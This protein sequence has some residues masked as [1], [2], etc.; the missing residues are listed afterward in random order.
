M[1][2]SDTEKKISPFKDFLTHLKRQGFVIGVDH[3]LRLQALLDMLG[4]NSQP[5]EL[6][7]LICPI[8]A[9][10]E[11]Q[12][13]QFYNAFDLYFKPAK[14]LTPDY[15]EISPPESIE[16]KKW[17]YFLLGIFLLIIIAI[18]GY[19]QV[20][21]KP[22]Q[23]LKRPTP[24]P[25]NTLES[26][27]G[28][29]AEPG[30]AGST[31]GSTTS[32]LV[33]STANGST[34]SSPL[35]QPDTL[36]KSEPE[37][38]FYQHY[39]Q[40]IRW[41]G[42]MTPIIIFLLTEWYKFNR[43]KLVLLKQQSKKPPYVWPI[44]VETS[45]LGFI[46]NEQ[47]YL[48]ARSMR[49]RLKS[50]VYQLDIN[51]TISHALKSA[52]FPEKFCYKAVTKPP[53]YLILIDL[54][55]FRDHYAHF[56][57]HIAK[58][59]EN[60]DVHV[61]RY[62]YENNPR[63][64]FQ[65]ASQERI[66]LSDLGTKYYDHRMII[67][68]SGE[69]IFDPVSGELEKWAVIFHTWRERAIL[70][71]ERPKKWGMK[72]VILAKEFI[73]LPASFD[74]LTALIDHFE[75]QLKPDIKTL[76]KADP[77]KQDIAFERLNDVAVLRH[78]LNE[79]TFQWLCACAVYPELHWNL[80][81]Y[82]GTLPCMPAN[83]INEENLLSLI[84]LPW[85]CEGDMPD[86][87]RWNLI[88]EL[89]KEKVQTIC[90][91]VIELLEKNSPQKES[92]A[93][94]NYYLNL[95]VQ[96]WM[97]S[98]NFREQR[99][100]LLKALDTVDRKRILQDYTFLRLLESVPKSPLSL[101]LP[102]RLRKIFYTKGVSVF[103][104]KSSIRFIF[105]VLAVLI[106]FLLFKE[107]NL[108]RV[109]TFSSCFIILF[110]CITEQVRVIGKDIAKKIRLYIRS[111]VDRFKI[112]T[113]KILELP[114]K[115]NVSLLL[116]SKKVMIVFMLLQMIITFSIFWWNKP[117]QGNVNKDLI[118]RIRPHQKPIS[119][120][121]L[122]QFKTDILKPSKVGLAISECIFDGLFNRTVDS[123]GRLSYEKGLADKLLS[124]SG[125]SISKIWY[126]ILRDDRYWHG[127]NIL[128]TNRDVIHTFKCIEGGSKSSWRERLRLD[129]A[130]EPY[131]VPNDPWKIEFV[132]KGRMNE[133]EVMQ[134]LAFKIIPQEFI[135]DGE[136]VSLRSTYMSISDDPQWTIFNQN[137]IG[138][139]PYKLSKTKSS[140]SQIVLERD[141]TN[142]K[143][144]LPH[145]V[146]FKE[147]SDDKLLSAMG[148]TVNFMLYIPDNYRNEIKKKVN[149]K[150]YKYT[151][152]YFY[153]L[154]FGNH[155][156]EIQKNKVYCII[157][158]NEKSQI[159]SLIGIPTPNPKYLNHGPFPWNWSVF[160]THQSNP[161]ETEIANCNFQTSS[162][163]KI[164][165]LYNSNDNIMKAI[166]TLIS[167]ALNSHFTIQLSELSEIDFM[168]TLRT[169]NFELAL[170]SWEGFDQ[171][172]SSMSKLY[173][174]RGNPLNIV[175]LSREV[176]DLLTKHFYKLSTTYHEL[177]QYSIGKEIHEIIVS[178]K[179]YHYL[180][181]IPKEA[182]Y[183]SYIKNI[184]Q[185][186]IDPETFLSNIR[187]WRME[188][189]SE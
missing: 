39:W 108:V 121:P 60:E 76:Y 153:A 170:I 8:F 11:K 115:L 23:E 180:F 88:N 17:P 140:L 106:I 131:T 110:L 159:L 53:D 107:P 178:E 38:T 45:E 19:W 185:Y 30:L 114:G 129:I 122:M 41:L 181:T 27:S 42:I 133:M 69:E 172:Y 161:F 137:P 70:T 168:K 81:L 139:G 104:L 189:V 120:N 44:Q 51:Q 146:I 22:P 138:T 101:I 100:V 99:K 160:N 73:I 174:D 95:V 63:I 24:I 113:I 40:V 54:P 166:S 152:F 148:R 92:F 155:M 33:A 52:G 97:L 186:P 26:T 32:D 6:K 13:R 169:R 127:T 12:Q 7:Y 128:V 98:K 156:T 4:K 61:T 68:G 74:G 123:S 34:V 151:P 84:R 91:A 154:V 1:F 184:E 16:A 78:Y 94:D 118:I 134:L 82:L 62:Y 165:L 102:Q 36:D 141:Y 37:P 86:E 47:F 80:T 96:R 112:I 182:A 75:N 164:N 175:V 144:Q 90:A 111:F 119:Y 89:D 162:K 77:K 65:E 31:I 93:Y 143:E 163:E 145:H 67:F 149:V 158:E 59:L 132:F 136:K 48:A 105:T 117:W 10:S 79:D 85:F 87:L 64:C 177:E 187:K 50:E 188:K 157:N 35:V 66:Y 43:R 130:K 124:E 171:Y 72:E 55:A 173:T 21:V 58:L 5:S 83:L 49:Q 18:L 28:T 71:P 103:G 109:G 116:R 57:N 3:Y 147:L 20:Q 142:Y 135:F 46:K 176:E 56:S 2:Q 125:N 167:K 14:S 150:I 29:N 9:V 183:M 179:P 25:A 15:L 126:V